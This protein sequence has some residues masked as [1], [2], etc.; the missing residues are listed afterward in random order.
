MIRIRANAAQTVR[1]KAE[2]VPRLNFD[3]L[4]LLVEA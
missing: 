1:Q 2:L 4:F 3:S